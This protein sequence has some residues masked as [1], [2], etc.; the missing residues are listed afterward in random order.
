MRPSSSTASGEHRRADQD[1]VGAQRLHDVE[2]AL[3]P[4][5]VGREPLGIGRVEVAEGLVE[6]DGEAEVRAAS[7]DLR[8]GRRRRDEVG[9]E[10][11]DAVEAGRGGRG[12]LVL[13]RAGDA[14]GGDRG[15]RD[16]GR[17]PRGAAL[18]T[19]R[20]TRTF[21]LPSRRGGHG[22]SQPA[23]G[24]SRAGTVRAGGSRPVGR[25]RAR[26]LTTSPGGAP[27]RAS[28]TDIA[29][30]KI[31]STDQPAEVRAVVDDDVHAHDRRHARSRAGSRPRSRRGA[32]PRS[33]S[34]CWCGSGRTRSRPAGTRAARR[35]SARCGGTGPRR[36]RPGR[37]PASPTAGSVAIRP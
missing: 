3:G 35:P 17:G 34:S 26:R 1:Q 14:D 36:R 23:H 8:G 31:S 11:L 21:R 22:S 24:G 13:Q 29:A 25:R 27:R 19:A 37:R 32:P 16:A 20:R 2:L 7:P 33:S 6:V 30:M 15:A 18:V 5:Q 9:F 4:P 10:D 28:L 12:E